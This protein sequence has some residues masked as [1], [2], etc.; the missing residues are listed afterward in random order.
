MS[1][2]CWINEYRWIIRVFQIKKK[3]IDLKSV[4][5]NVNLFHKQLKV[6]VKLLSMY[7]SINGLIPL[8]NRYVLSS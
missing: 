4:I 1:N 2:V 6:R 3:I 8:A 5:V 7:K